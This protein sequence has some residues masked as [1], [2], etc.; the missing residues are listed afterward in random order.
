M[1]KAP[2]SELPGA[3]GGEEGIRTPA[4]FKTPA[5]AFRVLS[6]EKTLAENG[7]F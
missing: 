4:R 2:E 5:T 7:L 3:N 6:P 1:K